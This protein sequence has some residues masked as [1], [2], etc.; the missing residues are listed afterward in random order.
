ME[1]SH[2]VPNDH[3]YLRRYQALLFGRFCEKKINNYGNNRTG[4]G[5][6]K[7]F[8]SRKTVKTDSRDVVTTVI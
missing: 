1:L 3:Q 2:G 6:K 8:S 7:A 5:K 4:I